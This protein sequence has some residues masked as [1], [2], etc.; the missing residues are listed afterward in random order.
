MCPVF[1]DL[2]VSLSSFHIGAALLPNANF[3]VVVLLYAK[4]FLNHLLES[5]AGDVVDGEFVS[6]VEY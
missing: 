1:T 2:V 6:S 4:V 5:A 3:L